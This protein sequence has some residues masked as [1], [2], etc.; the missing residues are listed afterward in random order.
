MILHVIFKFLRMDFDGTNLFI[1]HDNLHIFDYL[2][3]NSNMNPMFDELMHA[4]KCTYVYTCILKTFNEM[5][6]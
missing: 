3:P 5:I 6:P 2:L 4:I 1:K